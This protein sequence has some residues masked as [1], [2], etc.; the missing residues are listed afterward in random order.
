M[1]W[2]AL[3]GLMAVTPLLA[4]LLRSSPRYIAAAGFALGLLP[5]I[6]GHYN[7]GAAPISWPAWQG[8]VKGIEITVVDAIA[9]AV[10]FASSKYPVPRLL[11]G[12][13]AFFAVAVLMSVAI[14][15]LKMASSFYAWQLLKTALLFLAIYRATCSSPAFP[16]AV[17]TGGIVGLTMNAGA[18]T[19]DHAGGSLQSG[20]WFGHQNLLGMASHFVIYP[21]FALLLAGRYQWRA[22]LALFAALMVAYAGG[23]RATIGLMVAGFIAT[24]LL[25]MR[26]RMSGRKVG[27]AVAAM[28]GIA[29]AS[30]FL[31][32]AVD[33]RST[34]ARESS[35]AE[36]DKMEK[37]ATMIIADY[38]FGVGANRYV[39]VTNVGGYSARAGV[40]WN[41]ANRAAL[42]HN[43]YY[44]VA[45]EMGWLGLASWLGLMT[46][47]LAL[48]FG[49]IPRATSAS[50][51]EM[52]AGLCVSFMVVAV[53]M[54][55]EWITMTVY[56][57]YLAAIAIGLVAGIGTRQPQRSPMT[58]TG[59]TLQARSA[60]ELKVPERIPARSHL[61]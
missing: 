8:S 26:F 41:G 48:A 32:S 17:L 61:F 9:V 22:L 56:V 16:I 36:R 1:K 34:E 43:T 33:R 42:V 12:S 14:S 57:H 39:I 52:A 13:F 6:L 49:A 50:E 21:A 58:S 4:V 28:I 38:P 10:L 3:L 27:F 47:I 15:P 60:S 2:I 18:A 5:F 25:S 31:L 54:Y 44:L 55:F 40:G 29:A 45:A 51:G 37:A 35:N 30:P 7:L 19:L 23:S 46:S 11:K 20:G 24:A 53:H 59:G